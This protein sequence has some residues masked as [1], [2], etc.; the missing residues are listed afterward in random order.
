MLV[1]AAEDYTGVSPAQSV[2]SPVYAGTYV[3]ALAAN[4]I[5]ADVYD[6][7]ANGRKAPDALGVLSHYDAVVW[8]TGDDTVTRNAGWGAGNV[9]RLA[10]DLMFE[11]RA[12]M[13]EG[14]RVLLAG[15]R[16]TQQFSGAV[17]GSQRYDPQGGSLPCND[18][19]VAYRCLLLRGS[20]D[21]NNDVLQYW[22]G[23]FLVTANAGPT[24][25]RHLRRQ[26]GRQPV[27]RPEFRLRPGG[28]VRQRV[29]HHDERHPA[30]DRLPAVRVDGAPRATTGRAA[31]SSRAS[32]SQYVYSNSPT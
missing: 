18:A 25:R 1:V 26:R 11:T 6:V 9:A 14:G 22:Y 13:N 21:G 19:A 2:T 7:D 24:R 8:E 4:G 3:A 23:A 29:V 12:Y 16:A 17:V 32:G 31:R 30:A 15:K 27:P 5:T 20:G 28:A 10:Q